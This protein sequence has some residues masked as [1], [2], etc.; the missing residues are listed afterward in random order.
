MDHIL[1]ILLK[2]V[3]SYYMI[4]P[5]NKVSN[6]YSILAHIFLPFKKGK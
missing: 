2:Y 3:D 1:A 6:T 4:V 5:Q